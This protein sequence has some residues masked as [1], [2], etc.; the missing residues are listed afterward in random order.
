MENKKSKFSFFKKKQKT[1]NS[2]QIEMLQ[3]IKLLCDNPKTEVRLDADNFS[4]YL[5]TNKELH[6]D[7]ILDSIGVH[8]TNTEFT[9]TERFEE[10]FLSELK[11]IAKTRCQKDIAN[12]KLE[13]LSRKNKMLLNMRNSLKNK[14]NL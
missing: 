5:I 2:N 3:T 8:I 9:V 11:T 4:D 1:Y 6:Y 12:S 7:A 14:N 13:I 10:K